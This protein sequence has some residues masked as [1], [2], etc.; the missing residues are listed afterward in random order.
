MSDAP[1][2]ADA[3][4]RGS[5][6][7][8]AVAGFADHL[9]LERGLSGNTVDAYVRDVGQLADWCEA[10]GIVD[11][12]EVTLQVLRRFIGAGRRKGLARASIARKRASLRTFYGWALRR[13]L[14]THDPAAPLD[15]PRLDKRLPK[16]MRR[17]QVAA[18]IADAHGTGPL[19]R[20]DSAV[21][22]LL[23]A[24]G[25]RVSELVALDLAAVDLAD[26]AVRLHGKGDKER[27]VPLG[28]PAVAAVARWLAEG[29]PPL[30]SAAE[31][32]GRPAPG[33][34]VFLGARGARM[35][36]G[37]AYRMVARRGL[38][39]GVGHVTPHVLRHSYATHLLEGGADLRSVQELLG[40]AALATTQGYTHVTREHLRSAY[41][42]AHPRA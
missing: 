11:P 19:D 34:A 8:A 1:P 36:R 4:P 10:F 5:A 27:I 33:D 23:Y 16:A 21:L 20:R 25:A 38:R 30:V 35:D 39:S 12:D 22:E 14:V 3:V 42:Q 9:A 31:S 29:R 7:R 26:A 13:G 40:H 41:A 2:H 24:S 32:A 6:W 17:D 15:A 18:L 37:E 28:Q